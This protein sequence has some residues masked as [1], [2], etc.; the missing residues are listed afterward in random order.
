MW[1]NALAMS[2]KNLKSFFESRQTE[3]RRRFI[4]DHLARSH[5]QKTEQASCVADYLCKY[6]QAQS[7]RHIN[8]NG[9]ITPED[10]L[11]WY[12]RE[13]DRQAVKLICKPAEWPEPA[14]AVR[15]H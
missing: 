10:V 12:N 5:W 13:L 15:A 2:T 3:T 1:Y 9:I 7:L 6:F 14:R 11:R 8:N 4:L